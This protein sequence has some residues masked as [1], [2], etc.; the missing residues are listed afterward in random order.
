MGD[1]IKAKEIMKKAGL[2]VIPGSEGIVATYEDAAAVAN[3]I[4][5]PVLLK[6]V[7]G[8][9]G[10]GMRI[11]KD[12]AELERG[13]HV[14]S[15][16][17]ANAFSN[18]DLYLEKLLIRP[19]HIE[20][21]VIGDRFGN[22]LHI[23]ERDC[24]IQRRHQKLIE[25]TPSP[26]MTESL[27]YKMGEAAI[28]GAASVNYLGVGT[29]EFLVDDKRNFYFMEMN[30]RIQV[31]HPVTEEAYEIDLVKE[32][33]RVA[34]GEKVSFKQEQLI[35]KWC[36]IECRINAEDPDKDFR[37]GPGKITG[38]HVPGGFGV[39]VD[40][41]V[42]TGYT[43]PPY[44]DSMAAKLITK[45]RTRLGAIKKMRSALDEFIIEGVPTTIPF[46]QRIFDLPEFVAG[47]YDISFVET[48]YK[49]SLEKKVSAEESSA[50]DSAAEKSIETTETNPADLVEQTANEK[51]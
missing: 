34:L 25:E 50:T 15:T 28:K 37:P 2:P 4:G 23:G 20:I 42:Y 9:G 6:A 43:I 30:T 1:K 16:E 40:K 21:Q 22:F 31:E 26:F 44:Y 33:M 14:A 39:R 35:P 36:V 7:A 47:D 10:K 17:A 19:R 12:M 13:F 38:L 51:K 27:R 48:V 18:P 49:N 11:C 46:H 3:E 32:Q 24:S 41:A 8:G 29:I 5:F 45:S